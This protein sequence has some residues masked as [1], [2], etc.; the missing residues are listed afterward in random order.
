M[1]DVYDSLE[2]IEKDK[3]DG[4]FYFIVTIIILLF[5]SV[6]V[7]FSALFSCVVVDGPSME[8]TVYSNDVLFMSVYRKCTYEDIV[9]ISGEKSNDDLLIKRV[10]GM[11]GDS[12]QIKG[13]YV[14]R[15]K[16]GEKDFKKLIEPYTKQ[17]GITNMEGHK[18]TELF[19]EEKIFLIPEGEIFYL[20]DNRG[21]S[22]DSR[23]YGTCKQSQIEGVVPDWALKI[24]PIVNKMSNL[25]PK[26]SKN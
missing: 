13:G 2:Q 16:A 15:K 6:A 12:I 3:K 17:P 26:W 22:S 20:G 25:F 11:G 4:K 19:G 23:D 14:W 9:I 18:L 8:N 5:A 7:L 10:I 1:Y 24:R 21:N